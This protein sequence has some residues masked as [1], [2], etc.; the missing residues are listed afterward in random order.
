MVKEKVVGTGCLGTGCL[1][2]LV[3]FDFPEEIRGVQPELER[4]QSVLGLET[5]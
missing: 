4:S 1:V 3:T 2:C 5:F